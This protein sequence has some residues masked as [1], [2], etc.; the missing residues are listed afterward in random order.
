MKSVTSKPRRVPG[1]IVWLFRRMVRYN[2]VDVAVGDLNEIYEHYPILK[3]R[4]KQIAGSLSGGEQ[5]MLAIARALMAKP[6]F[7]LMDEPSTGL[8]PKLVRELSEVIKNLNQQGISIL[9]VEQ[10]SVLALSI[11]YRAYVLEIG[12]IVIQGNSQEL[13][14]NDQVRVAYIGK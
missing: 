14:N 1:W 11:S 4:S 6:R 5:Q 2:D 7:L 8:S 10:N 12:N 3:E 13:L 9:L